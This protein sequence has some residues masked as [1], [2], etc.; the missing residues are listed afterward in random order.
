MEK[1]PLKRTPLYSNH[2]ELKARM[3]PFAGYD[4]PV[5]YQ[6][7]LEETKACRKG[8]GLFDVSHMGQFSIRGKK[9]LDE[10]IRSN[11]KYPE[12]ALKQKIQG[13]VSVDYDIDVFGNVMGMITMAVGAIAGI[14]LVVGAIGIL[15]MMWITVRERTEEIGLVRAVGV[16]DGARRTAPPEGR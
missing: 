1:Q 14:S 2:L 11:M 9:A 6:G 16:S 4:M 7:V 10:F 8:I 3:V 15:T 13:M 12:E 5:Q